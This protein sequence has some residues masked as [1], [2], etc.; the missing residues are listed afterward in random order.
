MQPMR[1]TV[2]TTKPT[3][4]PRPAARASP[5]TSSPVE[6]ETSHPSL[7][8]MPSVIAVTKPANVIGIPACAGVAAT[9][10]A[11]CGTTYDATAAAHNTTSSK[12]NA[13]NV[14]SAV[15]RNPTYSRIVL[16]TIHTA[17]TPA[18]QTGDAAFAGAI[19]SSV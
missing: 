11:A 6:A 17:P 5:L 13:K 1:T 16:A 12:S 8:Q 4:P 9:V 10:A 14:I 18:T 3:M 7:I 19:S 2:V 15:G